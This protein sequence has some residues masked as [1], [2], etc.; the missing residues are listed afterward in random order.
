[1]WGIFVQEEKNDREHYLQN[2]SK[3]NYSFDSTLSQNSFSSLYDV[4]N[5]EQTS[6]PFGPTQL[7]LPLTDLVSTNTS[8]NIHDDNGSFFDEINNGLHSL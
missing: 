7:L 5:E 6:D 4:I 8:Y 3:D 2:I 1:M